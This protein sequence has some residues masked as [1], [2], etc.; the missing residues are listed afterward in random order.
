[1]VQEN[2]I[3]PGVE[4]TV[5][6][7][8]PTLNKEQNI[9]MSTDTTTAKVVE[10]TVV[11]PAQTEANTSATTTTKPNSSEVLQAFINDQLTP[12]LLREHARRELERTQT[13]E[14]ADLRAKWEKAK[15]E[16]K[17]GAITDKSIE[18]AIAKGHAPEDVTSKGLLKITAKEVI[19]NSSIKEDNEMDP[20]LAKSLLDKEILTPSEQTQ[21][22]LAH[23]NRL[24]EAEK[25]LGGKKLTIEQKLAILKAHYVGL[26]EEGENGNEAG[27][28]NLKQE[29]VAEKAR[30]LEEA[31][32]EKDER[33]EIIE[34]GLTVM[35][36]PPPVGIPAREYGLERNA[37]I[38]AFGAINF[39]HPELDNIKQKILDLH[40]ASLAAGGSG[41]DS[42][43]LKGYLNQ[44][45]NAKE[46]GRLL[47]ANALSE[48]EF[49]ERIREIS[50]LDTLARGGGRAEEGFWEEAGNFQEEIAKAQAAGD[51]AREALLKEQFRIAK[52]K[53]VGNINVSETGLRD[54]TLK[55]IV[56]DEEAYLRLA[57]KIIGGPL[58]S[59]TGDYSLGF[60]GQINIDAMTNLL[61]SLSENTTEPDKR[62]TFNAQ[63]ENINNIK[64]GVRTMHEL[65]K[66]IVTGRLEPASQMA[67]NVLPKYQ[68][69]LQKWKGVALVER[70]LEAAHSVTVS[71][72]GYINV[73]N[74]QKMMGTEIN[75]VTGK[76]EVDQGE[77]VLAEFRQLLKTIK[78]SPALAT[79]A[80]TGF[81][82]MQEWEISLAYN[83]GRAM[84]NN[85]QR[86]AAWTSQGQ[87]PKGNKAWESTPLEG[88]NKIFN[89]ARWLYHRFTIG[90]GRGG[91]RWFDRFT[92]AMQRYKSV[93]GWGKTRIEK[94]RDDEIKMFELPTMTGVRDWMASWRAV[95][96][97]LRQTNAQF[98]LQGSVHGYTI[99][100]KDAGSNFTP[101][102]PN[103]TSLGLMLNFSSLVFEK[104]GGKP[105]GW[106]DKE[107]TD[108]MKA[109]YLRS[110]FFKPPTAHHGGGAHHPELRDDLQ[111]ALGVV[112]RYIL[113][114]AGGHHAHSSHE[115]NHVKE[116]IRTLIWKRAA[117][118]NPLAIIPY[119]NKLKLKKD[120]F[121]KEY[122]TFGGKNIFK[123]KIK[124]NDPHAP[125]GR[126]EL[127]VD[128]NVLQRK[129]NLLNEI[130]LA[131]VRGVK[132][133]DGITYVPGQEPDLDYKLQ[134]AISHVQAMSGGGYDPA[135]PPDHIRN[136]SN[137][138][139]DELRFLE[140]VGAETER[141]APD[142]AN[143]KFAFAP[144]M[145]DVILED[146]DYD[147]PGQESFAR[148][149]RD[150]AQF[151]ATNGAIAEAMDNL[152]LITD[153]HKMV[154]FIA[155]FSKGITGVHGDE[156]AKDK[157]YAVIDATVGFF[158]RGENVYSAEES[159]K[160]EEKMSK[161][162]K[163]KRWIKQQ[164]E[165]HEFRQ[166]IHKPNSEAQMYYNIKALALDRG[167][168]YEAMED[169][170][171]A[172]LMGH[173]QEEEYKKR[174]GNKLKLGKFL[175]DLF[176][177]RMILEGLMRG[178]KG[179]TIVAGMDILKRSFKGAV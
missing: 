121:G 89:P 16:A 145:N 83:L 61:Q 174:F 128:W 170:A 85:Q 53:F 47:G 164:D 37:A 70:L 175:L 143:V 115:Q 178:F 62:D 60:Y 24:L 56:D 72:D 151:N 32:L 69:V 92:D 40:N 15:K 130:K 158:R 84:F 154:E 166:K 120:S 179:G 52:G 1:M 14:S 71:R 63:K 102:N 124:V 169:L 168:T 131:K 7:V 8:N 55:L 59:E 29:Q 57:F 6:S 58:Q 31:G 122:E 18:A 28:Y 30:I 140:E 23:K 21:L 137:L 171:A 97:T 167:Q 78:A 64:E 114:P 101:I 4:L 142:L 50:Q 109:D 157:S 13:A 152:G 25:V 11:E 153:Y 132:N 106:G 68:Q 98:E 161:A 110:V 156:A 65:N 104:P 33:R 162:K 148:H 80:L 86:K 17:K 111:S 74:D 35:G 177:P 45:T 79:G 66:Y 103:D 48:H 73:D 43:S 119:L 26:G 125:G 77:S 41:I 113:N 96:M 149:F 27:V 12:E 42:E 146:T 36:P 76:F 141:V 38:T 147:Q 144:F 95:G 34:S 44:W 134:D 100:H 159:Y 87:V 107:M 172:G 123:E 10:N 127:D 135:L 93:E 165:F 88:F 112:Y 136:V 160:G 22:L 54:H 81:E 91:M 138:S 3:Q 49:Q 129:L 173:V 126:R 2:T 51:A 99:K 39:N 118:D 82:N 19:E 9:F 108:H 94:I 105:I 67:E 75:K 20:K 46:S 117:E 176:I 90:A 150:M 133:P 139:P 155:K 163:I 5:A 116:E